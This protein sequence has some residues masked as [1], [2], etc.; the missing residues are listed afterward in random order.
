M[1]DSLA[2]AWMDSLEWP[3]G[4]PPEGWRE[5]LNQQAARHS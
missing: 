1:S 5:M 2:P 4:E 3:E